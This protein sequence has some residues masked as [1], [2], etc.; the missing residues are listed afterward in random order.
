MDNCRNGHHKKT[1][2]SEFGNVELADVPH[3]KNAEFE[4]VIALK[5]SRKVS[6]S[7]LI[8]QIFILLIILGLLA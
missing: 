7:I 5:H 6:S 4:P 1:A 3:D 8:N 2:R